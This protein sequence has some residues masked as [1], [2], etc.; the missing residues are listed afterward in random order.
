[1]ISESGSNWKYYKRN[2]SNVFCVDSCRRGEHL[3]PGCSQSTLHN[4]VFYATN[5]NLNWVSFVLQDCVKG[6]GAG[7]FQIVCKS[8]YEKPRVFF[9]SPEYKCSST[10]TQ[11]ENTV[12]ACTKDM[13][14]EVEFVGADSF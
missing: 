12:S 3:G 1:M 8:C 4:G 13:L 14:Q 2:Q 6:C 10:V 5:P 11:Q 7:A 9:A